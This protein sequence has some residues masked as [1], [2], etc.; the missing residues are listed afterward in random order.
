MVAMESLSALGCGFLYGRPL[1]GKATFVCY[2]FSY[3]KTGVTYTMC[4]T[5]LLICTLSLKYEISKTISRTKISA[6]TVTFCN[7]YK[8]GV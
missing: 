5:M 3:S 2:N 1:K 4:M 8:D 7:A 6:I